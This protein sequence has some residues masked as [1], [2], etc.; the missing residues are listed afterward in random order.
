MDMVR[1]RVASF[2][3]F[4][5]NYEPEYVCNMDETGLYFRAHPNKRLAC[6]MV[7]GRKLQKERATLALVMVSV[8]MII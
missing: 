1:V 3:F 5:S 7:W 2:L 6:G 4:L 8:K